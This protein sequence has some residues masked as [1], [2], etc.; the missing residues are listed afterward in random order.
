MPRKLDGSVKPS[1]KRKR[2]GDDDD[3]DDIDSA[4]SEKENNKISTR[5]KAKQVKTAAKPEAKAAPR[6]KTQNSGS[7]RDAKKLYNDTVKEL[8]KHIKALD[9]KVKAMSPNSRA[10]MIDSYARAAVKHLPA[11]K[12]LAAMCVDEAVPLAFNLVMTMAD[13]SHTDLNKTAKMCGYGDSEVPFGKMDEKLLGLIEQR[14]KPTVPNP[15]LT[16]VSHRWTQADADVGE[17]KTSNG[18]NKQQRGQMARQLI[19]WEHHRREERRARREA[20]E[21]WVS[22]ALCDLREERD[23]LAQYGVEGYFPESIARLESLIDP[24]NAK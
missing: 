2:S 13:A 24:G 16:P 8:N 15:F 9:M 19:E 12:K 23:Y 4:D 18:P 14:K 17:F 7:L 22:V 21:D 11:V 1:E 5:P 20:A 3:I 10:I 6:A